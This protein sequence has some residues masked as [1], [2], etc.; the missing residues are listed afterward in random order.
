ML[1]VR[2]IAPCFV[3]PR[4]DNTAPPL[5]PL[6]ELFPSQKGYLWL[7]S[8]ILFHVVG[9]L[10]RNGNNSASLQFLNS[11]AQNWRAELLRLAVQF[12][13]EL[14]KHWPTRRATKTVPSTMRFT[15]CDYLRQWLPEKNPR[16]N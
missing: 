10:I 6:N 15:P 8:T 5:L 16:P 3:R 4:A 11:T 14:K 13:T 2:S 1:F 7:I 12:S 9:P